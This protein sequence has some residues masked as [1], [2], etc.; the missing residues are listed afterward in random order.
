MMGIGYYD[1]FMGLYGIRPIDIGE[2]YVMNEPIVKNWVTVP[3]ANVD[4]AFKWAKKRHQY[5]TNDYAVIGGRREHYQ[6]GND[7]DNFDFFWVVSEPMR[8]FER[9]FG[10]EL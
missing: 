1:A 9:L 6:K 4:K 5:I 3:R 2:E 7:E 8:E 10:V